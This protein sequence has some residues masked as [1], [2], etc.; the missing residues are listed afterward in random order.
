MGLR[1]WIEEQ[2]TGV[3]IV[4]GL[5]VAAVGIVLLIVFTVIAAAVVGTF[6][7]DLGSEVET[8]VQAGATVQFDG[9]A[10][11]VTATFTSNQNADY[12]LVEWSTQ[13]GGVEIAGTSGD[14][15]VGDGQARLHSVGS[16]VV[17]AE[18]DPGADTTVSV[19]VT[20][21]GSDGSR[22]VVVRKDGTV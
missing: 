18:T 21:V 8:S 5:G 16:E 15:D 12:L 17:L 11:E 13:G 20:A 1:D 22:T 19:T 3:L 9:D 4:V 7:L 10:G 6:V 2:S 14:V